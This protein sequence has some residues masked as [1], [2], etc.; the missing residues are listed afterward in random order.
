MADVRYCRDVPERAHPLV[1]PIFVRMINDWI[2]YQQVAKE[3][4]V[5]ADTLQDWRRG[6]LP[7]IANLL[8]VYRVVGLKLVPLLEDAA[9]QPV[10]LSVSPR[11]PIRQFICK[12][13]HPIDTTLANGKRRCS[14]CYKAA[15]LEW[16]RKCREA[17]NSQRTRADD[18]P[19]S[20][21]RNV[22][23]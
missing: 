23:D 20:P 13:G 9:V 12:R 17:R 8:A 3:S 19:V 14:T 16:S 4:G 5:H 15:K 2:T 10:S 6:R 7:E 22:P 18:V 1:K 21:P 11:P